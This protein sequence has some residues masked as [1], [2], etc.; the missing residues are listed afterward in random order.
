MKKT[1]FILGAGASAPYKFPL[2]SELLQRVINRV[3]Q[4]VPNLFTSYLGQH[5]HVMSAFADALAKS[6]RTSVDAFLEHR[7]EF[8]ELGKLAIAYALMD[9]EI[10]GALFESKEGAWLQYLF[11]RLNR[12][13]D[14]FGNNPVSFITFNYDRSLE[15]Y[16]FICLQ[17]S[18]GKTD[19]ECAEQLKKIPIVHVHGTLGALHWQGGDAIRK[20]SPEI[21]TD[22]LQIAAREIKII[23]E[24]I[25][26]N[27]PE[28][29]RAKKLLANA[30]QIYILGFGYDETNM[31]RIGLNGI[32]VGIAHGSGYGL[33]DHERN[34]KMRSVNGRITIHGYDCIGM[35]RNVVEW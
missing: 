4:P 28:I 9:R 29:N 11:N 24:P 16:L 3:I 33:T 2:G 1:V 35:L 21:T 22:A 7:P 8:I 19:K 25:G 10:T 20:Y 31:A 32:P 13:F 12:P 26:G 5:P 23:H 14:D 34:L 30:E 15:H 27:D 18:H 17:N 6:G